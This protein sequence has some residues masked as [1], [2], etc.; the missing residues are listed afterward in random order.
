MGRRIAI[1]QHASERGKDASG[2]S[3]WR[4]IPFWQ[5]DG[6]EVFTVFGPDDYQPAD[7]LFFHVDLSEIPEGYMELAYRY[8][9]TVNGRV[10]DI[11]KTAFSEHLLGM[12][13]VWNGPVIV[14]SNRNYGGLP[15]ALRGVPRLDGKGFDA[16][17]SSP[18]DYQLY[19]QLQD[20]PREVFGMP[21]LVVQ[22]FLP[23]IEDDLFHIHSYFFLGSWSK[24]TRTASTHPIVKDATRCAS[25]PSKVAPEILDLRQRLGFDYGKFDYVHH[26]GRVFLLDVNKTIGI[27]R[28][29]ALRDSTQQIADRQARA[30][31]LYS[32]FPASL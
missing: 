28:F 25:Y 6:H 29:L 16:P 31:G 23:E 19:A 17:F 18:L 4:L 15:E 20:V 27:G 10:R 12:G 30:K 1:L 11:R 3:L 32:L 24:C 8:P 22:R 13:D 5:E 2:Y 14:K 9:A 7:I 26:E 21:D